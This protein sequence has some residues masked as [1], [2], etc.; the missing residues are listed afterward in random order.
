MRRGGNSPFFIYKIFIY[1]A[2][3]KYGNEFH[4]KEYDPDYPRVRCV[5]CGYMN[6]CKCI[7]ENKVPWYPRFPILEMGGVIESVT[8]NDGTYV[9]IHDFTNWSINKVRDSKI[10]SYPYG[11]VVVEDFLHPD[12]LKYIKDNWPSRNELDENPK[13][14]F[15][16]HD[17]STHD[18]L[19]LIL[20]YIFNNFH[21]K[22][23]L[24]DKLGI[25]RELKEPFLSL[26]E[27][28]IEWAINDVHVD[29]P[30]FD[31]TFGL[32]LPDDESTIEYG[33][34]FWIPNRHTSNLEDTF[35]KSE[36]NFLFRAPFK[37]NVCYFMIR[38]NTSWHSSPDIDKE[39]TRK[40]LYGA[41]KK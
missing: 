18:K 40:H 8:H 6:S 16:L 17:V 5:K 32:F 38:N 10:L 15:A 23:Y 25:Q 41:F 7:N 2:R 34:E 19:N 31:V 39:I 12:L 1:M 35:Q 29:S 24:S 28:T 11:M 4:P 13:G 30:T 21:F 37:E 33:T 22:S 9:E 26:W 27:D 14:R 36:C 3:D 20:K